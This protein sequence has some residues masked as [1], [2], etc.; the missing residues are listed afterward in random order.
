MV[1]DRRAAVSRLLLGEAMN[2]DVKHQRYSADLSER[3]SVYMDKGS[4]PVF[5][6]NRGVMINGNRRIHMKNWE[7]EDLKVIV[8]FLER[9]AE[10]IRKVQAL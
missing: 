5:E 9:N 6:N 4:F 7:L 1:F 2:Y 3:V 8:D 10:V